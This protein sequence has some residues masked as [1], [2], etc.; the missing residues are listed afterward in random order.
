MTIGNSFI[1]STRPLENIVDASVLK[2]TPTVEE[3]QRVEPVKAVD[4]EVNVPK[5]V[6][7]RRKALTEILDTF[8]GDYILTEGMEPTKKAYGFVYAHKENAKTQ[9]NRIDFFR[10]SLKESMGIP[11]DSKEQKDLEL[12]IKRRKLLS[13]GKLDQLSKNEVKQLENIGT[14]TE[15]QQRALE[16]NDMDNYWN[17]TF[18]DIKK[19]ASTLT[20]NML[21]TLDDIKGLKVDER[22]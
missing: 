21:M 19:V 11:D 5:E 4:E 1:Q 20:S 14:L 7:A 9:M 17:D 12:L 16:Y 13:E 6:L 8:A 18:N 15:Y 2:K 22:A 3:I 10:N